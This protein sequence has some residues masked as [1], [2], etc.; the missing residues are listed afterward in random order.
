M[1]KLPVVR[2]TQRVKSADCGPTTARMMLEYFGIAR[3]TQELADQLRY[4]D[5]GTF[6]SDNGLLFLREGLSAKLVTANTILFDYEDRQRLTTKRKVITY[7]KGLLRS[8]LK[9]MS[10]FK[11]G[12]RIMLEFL[13]AGGSIAIEIPTFKH[14]Q[15]AIDSHKLVMALV[16]PNAFSVDGSFHHFVVV[17]GYDKQYV[18]ITDPWP[19][20]TV[21]KV[22]IEDFMYS[23]H[24]STVGDLDTGSF[25]IVGKE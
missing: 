5:F 20:S 8:R 9:T 18:Y 22:A 19:K 6:I 16:V 15:N 11:P 21:T 2:H 13:E 4:G 12:I 1:K 23:V 10:R 25:L 14:I 17:N 3:F 24:A 7:L